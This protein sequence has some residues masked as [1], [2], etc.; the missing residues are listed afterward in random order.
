MNKDYDS[1]VYKSGLILSEFICVFASS[2]NRRR[3]PEFSNDAY[4]VFLCR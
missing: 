2:L 1:M 3:G 4:F